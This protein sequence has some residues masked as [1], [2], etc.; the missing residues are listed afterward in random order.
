MQIESEV[1]KRNSA[2]LSVATVSSASR[3]QQEKSPLQLIASTFKTVR[4]MH[5]LNK[6]E[7]ARRVHTAEKNIGSLESATTSRLATSQTITPIINGWGQNGLGT[8]PSEQGPNEFRT[9]ILDNIASYYGGGSHGLL[10]RWMYEAGQADFQKATGLSPAALSNYKRLERE[11]DFAQLAAMAKDI[12]ALRKCQGAN[13]WGHQR[14]REI[15]KALAEDSTN[16]GRP[17]V[18]EKLHQMVACAG[19]RV[20]SHSNVNEILGINIPFRDRY[21]LSRFR[22]VAWE[23]I[24]PLVQK[25]NEIGFF[26]PTQLQKFKADWQAGEAEQKPWC[27]IRLGQLA[28]A[29]SIS[30]PFIAE[31]LGHKESSKVGSSDKVNHYLTGR[32]S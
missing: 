19:S 17:E 26:S 16:Y 27:H 24:S 25:L 32:H 4:E 6:A 1:T 29:R 12:F 15:R 18:L 28:K 21:D 2:S 23:T 3:P 13:F 5:G 14:G 10:S 22:Y 7:Y 30:S 9:K 31:C 11:Y 20:H 8:W